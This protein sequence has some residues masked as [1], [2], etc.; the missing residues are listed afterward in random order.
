MVKRVTQHEH[1]EELKPIQTAS[2]ISRHSAFAMSYHR[3]RSE[4]SPGAGRA[5]NSGRRSVRQHQRA[6]AAHRGARRPGSSHGR[7]AARQRRWRR[8]QRRQRRRLALMDYRRRQR[9]ESRAAGDKCVT[10]CKAVALKLDSSCFR[11]L[12]WRNGLPPWLC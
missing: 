10:Y 7:A 5:S 3:A 8:E 6:V 1:S 9:T 11:A 12:G 4:F 2:G